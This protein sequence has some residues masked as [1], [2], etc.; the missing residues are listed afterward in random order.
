MALEDR[1]PCSSQYLSRLISRCVTRVGVRPILNP[2]PH[3]SAER[4]RHVS[5]GDPEAEVSRWDAVGLHGGDEGG[6]SRGFGEEV[7]RST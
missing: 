2:A 1:E 7:L 4:D 5:L 3:L 6:I